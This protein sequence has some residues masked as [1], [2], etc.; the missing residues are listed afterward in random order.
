MKQGLE[1]ELLKKALEQDKTI[2]DDVL[3]GVSDK[4]A[5]EILDTKF[6]VT[7]VRK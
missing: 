2:L 6:D 5:K 7:L 4:K 1:R 3:D